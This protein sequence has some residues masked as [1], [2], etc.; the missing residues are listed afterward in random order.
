M[1]ELECQQLNLTRKMEHI[2][3]IIPI[4]ETFNFLVKHY[5][6]TCQEKKLYISIQINKIQ[7]V[8]KSNDK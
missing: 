4:T 8:S 2:S 6:K 5:I 7:I 1:A 3:K